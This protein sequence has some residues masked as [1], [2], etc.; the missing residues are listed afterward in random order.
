VFLLSVNFRNKCAY[1]L[2][3]HKETSYAECINGKFQVKE[4]KLFMCLKIWEGD[5]FTG[6]PIGLRC[7]FTLPIT[8]ISPEI[9]R[10]ITNT[11]K[12]EA[13]RICIREDEE[14]YNVRVQNIVKLLLCSES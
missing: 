11:A 12:Y 5:N 7:T 4:N 14:A 6:V 2:D 1:P 9:A 10:L 3:I 8:S 13:N